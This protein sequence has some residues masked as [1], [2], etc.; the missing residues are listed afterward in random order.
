LS[1]GPAP[2]PVQCGAH[3]AG[4]PQELKTIDS[5]P[6]DGEEQREPAIG[7][8]AVVAAVAAA[9]GAQLGGPLGAAVGAGM[10][11]TASGRAR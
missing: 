9:A 1:P 4:H 10:H 6:T 7:R 5:M 2:A 3:R 11:D 8:Q